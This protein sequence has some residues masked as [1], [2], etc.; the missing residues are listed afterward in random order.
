MSN[1]L[2]LW[3]TYTELM[4]RVKQVQIYFEGCMDTKRGI[5]VNKEQQLSEKAGIN[6]IALLCHMVL[7]A[8]LVLSYLAEVVQGKR[9]IGYY[10]VFV[11]LALVPLGMEIVA[12]KR[13]PD[14]DMIKHV[15]GIGYGI[16]YTFVLF[17]T[18]SNIAFT[19]VIPAYLVVTLFSDARYCILVSSACCVVNIANVA[20]RFIVGGANQI[21][22]TDAE[23]QVFVMII[24]AVFLCLS[25]ATLGKHNKRKMDAISREKDNVSNLLST[26]MGISAQMTDGIVN[27][28][29]RMDELGNA[30][31]E[32]RNAMQEVSS[33]TNDT[34]ESVQ[35][36]LGKTE[37]I[38]NHIENMAK[39][40]QDI[41]GNMDQAKQ[42][43]QSGKN[44]IDS[45]LAQVKASD[46][47]GQEAVQDM[48]TLEE[49]TSNMQSIID[50]ITSVASQT[51][52]LAL[53]AS[54]EAA[55][56]GEAGRGFAVV[57]TEISNLA[58]QTQ[59]ATVNITEVI[60]NVSDKLKIASE[61]VEELLASNVQQ[62]EAAKHAAE[63]FEKIAEST[64]QVDARSS[65]LDQAVNRLAEA[66][67]GIVDSVQTIS[68]IM[69]E[70]SAHSQETFTVSERNAVIVNEVS[71]LVGEIN[72]EAKLLNQDISTI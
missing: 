1:C 43:V 29:E 33:G 14:T 50:M 6:R 25:T 24:V 18:T 66:N 64:T 35:S 5:K 36:Q 21:T 60:Q 13:N 34:A 19:F 65:E 22:T 53:N 7:S 12:Y 46:H 68:A 37:D 4:R 20:Y 42:D 8:V 15:L 56:A 2:H 11:I 32:T 55:R 63:S 38:Q 59:S 23:I 28:T 52:L 48:K 9:T 16:F 51:S 30:V 41:A 26:I 17:T 57:A 72:E 40:T 70:V 47:A 58:N 71:K 27:V 39:I 69:E 31:S 54:I 49:Y 44:N 67:S 45:L 3:Y 62:S 10:V 61:A